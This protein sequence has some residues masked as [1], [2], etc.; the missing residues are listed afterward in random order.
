MT[1]GEPAV[2]DRLPD[3][4][5]PEA[6]RPIVYGPIPKPSGFAVSALVLGIIGLFLSWIT[7]GIPSMLAVIFGHIGVSR[8]RRGVG[9]GRGM[10]IAGMVL[11]YLVIGMFF[12]LVVGLFAVF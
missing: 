3:S 2:P 4:R 5:R 10:A 7:F 11:G 8:V 6:R 1:T 12:L 9:D